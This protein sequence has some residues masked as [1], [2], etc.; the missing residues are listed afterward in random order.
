[1]KKRAHITRA[2]ST[3]PAVR[4]APCA[5]RS[6]AA[7]R[8]RVLALPAECT[9]AHAQTLKARLA[10]LLRIA[11]CVTIDVALVQRIDTASLQLL[12]AF[13]HARQAGALAL[14]IRGESRAFA[15]ATQLL[16]LGGILHPASGAAPGDA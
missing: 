7:R 3:R 8:P 10:M 12:V 16:G 9:L 2:G 13:V 15:Q 6:A 5:P 4:R 14:S 11:N 1:M